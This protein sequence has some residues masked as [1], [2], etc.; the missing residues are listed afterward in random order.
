MV[1]D[2]GVILLAHCPLI[3]LRSLPVP[4]EI[5]SHSCKRFLL[6]CCGGRDE[7]KVSRIDCDKG[8]TVI[9]GIHPPLLAAWNFPG[10]KAQMKEGV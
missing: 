9:C 3:F 5:S 7:L 4:W 8:T 2:G 10:E 6:E 1:R